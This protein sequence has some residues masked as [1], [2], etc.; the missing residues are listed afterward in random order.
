MALARVYLTSPPRRIRRILIQPLIGA[1][2][3]PGNPTHLSIIQS[4]RA[5]SRAPTARLRPSPNWHQRRPARLNKR[6]AKFIKRDARRPL[7]APSCRRRSRGCAIAPISDRA[8]GAASREL[9]IGSALY[10][11]GGDRFAGSARPV[12]LEFL[13]VAYYNFEGRFTE[14]FI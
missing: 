14:M 5:A 6:L 2:G 12:L 11:R 4:P 7:C 3:I 9:S 1:L 13:D 10:S 8:D